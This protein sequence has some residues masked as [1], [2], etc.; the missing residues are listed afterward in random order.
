[1]ELRDVEMRLG[2]QFPELFHEMANS[3][4]MDYLIH[5]REWVRDKIASDE[6]YL[7]RED[8]FGEFM[9]DCQLFVFENL[10]SAYDEL[11]ECLNF[12]LEIYPER[13]SI[14][15]R[16]RLVP[17][18]RKISGDKY[19]FLYEEGEKEPKIVVYGHDT[20]DVDLWADNFEEFIYFQILEDFLMEEE[21]MEEEMME[22][23]RESHSDYI[24]AHVQWLSD[25]HKRLLAET[26]IK[27]IWEQ[28][29]E[30]QEF[31]IWK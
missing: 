18:A 27:D 19:C 1:M 14:N 8:F 15:P 6:N 3:G 25:A 30:P 17:F 10:P 16:Y 29:P 9:G 22:E 7:C 31:N 28:V 24:K 11:Y 26:P 13:Q 21:M 23:D 12:D 5:S 4:M 20:G 2:I